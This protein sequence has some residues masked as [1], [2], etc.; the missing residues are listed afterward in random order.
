MQERIKNF[1][2]QY[3]K[4]FYI[5]LYHKQ[6]WQENIT[7]APV[8]CLPSRHWCRSQNLPKITPLTDE[9]SRKKMGAQISAFFWQKQVRGKKYL[10]EYQKRNSSLHY[11]F[12]YLSDYVKS[13]EAW[14]DDDYSLES[15]NES[16]AI[17]MVFAYDS[18]FGTLD[19]FNL[20]GVKIARILQKIFCD[21]ILNYELVD[22]QLL[23]SAFQIDQF[24][25]RKNQLHAIPE[26][27]ITRARIMCLDFHYATVNKK[28]SHRISIEEDSADDEI[29]N[30]IE[31]DFN[32]DNI[33]LNIVTVKFIKI[34]LDIVVN[35]EVR[36]MA[37]EFT[38]NTCNLK[39][40]SEELRLIGEK[41]IEESGIDGQPKLF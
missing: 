34:H 12:V 2:N 26:I 15:K 36:K 24:K 6:I 17:S 10:I 37:L 32:S 40:N 31:H 3:D 20:G 23:K 38:R 21:S 35:N 39:G 7:F 22:E 29:Y 25:Y 33:P 18:H 11:Y 41:F 13:Y 1:K 16:R 28:R 30:I 14:N 5:Y 19:T 27:G 9:D 8:D 4:A